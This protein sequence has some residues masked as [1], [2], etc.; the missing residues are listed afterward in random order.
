MEKLVEKIVCVREDGIEETVYIYQTYIDARTKDDP[1][2]FIPGNM[3]LALSN[4][5]HVTF[6]DEN[7]FSLTSGVILHRK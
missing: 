3:R 1:D 6:V 2:G 5:A 4:G 7:T